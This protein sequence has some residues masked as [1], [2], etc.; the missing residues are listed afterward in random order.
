MN[1]DKVL[2]RELLATMNRYKV[3]IALIC[4][5]SFAFFVQLTFWI[6]KQY[7]STFEINV[8]SKYFQSPLISGVIPDMF[9]IP[10]MRFAIDSMVKE[11]ISDDFI[12]QLGNRYDLY[13]G[14][15]DERIRARER[16]MLRDRFSYYSTGGQSYQ[17]SFSYKDPYIAKQIAEETLK[18]V[19]THIIDKRISTIE[20]VKDVMINKLNSFNASQSFSSRGSEKALAS[21][22]PEVLKDEL[23][24]LNSNIDALSTQLKETNPKIKALKERRATILS[25]LKEYDLKDLAKD[26]K[27]V[28]NQPF[29]MQHDRVVTEQLS[30]KFYAKYHDFNIALDIEKRSVESYIGVIKKPQLP[31]EAQWPKKRLFASLGF[32]VGL[33]FAFIYVYLKEVMAPNRNE[34]YLGEVQRLKAVNLGVMPLADKAKPFKADIARPRLPLLSF[35]SRGRA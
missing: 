23:I 29:P 16:Q 24:K 12:D 3:Q 11:A 20:L 25:W 21:K 35:G 19:N 10:E 8:Y 7:V 33:I 4:T 31:T 17:V 15:K 32:I 14:T 18:V 27:H 26:S 5:F 34:R 6:E 28:V 13:S 2:V 30:S 22:S 1:S 9:N